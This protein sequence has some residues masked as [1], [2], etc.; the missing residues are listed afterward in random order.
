MVELQYV[1]ALAAVGY[2]SLSSGDV[3]ASLPLTSL[4]LLQHNVAL[5]N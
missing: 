3:L 4:E 2:A 5:A 1:D